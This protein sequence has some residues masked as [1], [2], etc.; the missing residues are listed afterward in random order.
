MTSLYRLSNLAWMGP[1]PMGCL[2]PGL[3]DGRSQSLRLPLIIFRFGDGSFG[4]ACNES[5]WEGCQVFF[6]RGTAFVSSA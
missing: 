1:S 3:M 5:Y 4:T 2:L 6:A